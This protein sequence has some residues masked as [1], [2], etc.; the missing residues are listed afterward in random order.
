[1]DQE[2]YFD[3]IRE[4]ANHEITRLRTLLRDSRITEEEREVALAM[5]EFYEDS[6]MT[7]EQ[8]FTHLSEDIILSRTKSVRRRKSESTRSENS[9]GGKVQAA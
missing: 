4:E 5:L 8:S 9:P 7:A 6:S 2:H 3:F 1:M